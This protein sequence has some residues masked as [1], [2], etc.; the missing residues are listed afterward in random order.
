MVVKNLLLM[1]QFMGAYSDRLINKSSA[2]MLPSSAKAGRISYTIIQHN[3]C[4]IMRDLCFNPNLPGKFFGTFP[5][6]RLQI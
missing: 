1:H 3:S 6:R 2:Y 4:A 5:L